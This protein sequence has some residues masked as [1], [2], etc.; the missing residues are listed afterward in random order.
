MSAVHL[1]KEDRGFWERD[2]L[3]PAL[4][5]QEEKKLFQ[6]LEINP[7]DRKIRK[8]I[9]EKN[10]GLVRSW[11]RKIKNL[12]SFFGLEL[13]DLCQ[14]GT[15]GVMKAV[16][17]FDWK[18]GY[19]FSTYARWWIRQTITRTIGNQGKD[20]TMISL[21][22]PLSGDEENNPLIN[23]IIEDKKIGSPAVIAEEEI[24]REELIEILSSCLNPR[25]EKILAMRF[26]LEDGKC[27]T[28]EE[29]GDFFSITK[30]RVRQIQKKAL[31]K[32]KRDPRTILLK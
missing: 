5:S 24:L 30:E 20:G 7:G 10:T 29:T 1:Q 3:P 18:K 28:L 31:R 23:F 11:A 2:N 22:K 27:C 32:L 12:Y 19:K 14:T 13:E 25:E 17:K 15:I 21:D 4:S 9:I 8:E 6:R 16:D 26:G